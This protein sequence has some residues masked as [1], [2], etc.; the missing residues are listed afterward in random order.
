MR[1]QVKA[2]A[3][4]A[5]DLCWEESQ[6]DW[7]PLSKVLKLET[8]PETEIP[9]PPPP[10]TDYSPPTATRPKTAKLYLL[11]GVG[12]AVL[13]ALAFVFLGGD[14]SPDEPIA[15]GLIA[16]AGDWEALYTGKAHDS[17]IRAVVFDPHDNTIVAS[18]S[19]LDGDP[20]KAWSYVTGETHAKISGH[21][22]GVMCLAYH[23]TEELL[24]SGSGDDQVIIHDL[25][26]RQDDII[27]SHEP[28]KDRDG[29]VNALAWSAK[30]DWLVTGSMDLTV[31]LWNP[32]TGNEMR[33]ITEHQLEINGVAFNP[34]D[35]KIGASVCESGE[36]KIWNINDASARHL[37]THVD[38]A[39]AL[40]FSP[41]GETLAT[42]GNDSD[43]KIW[44]LSDGET[45]MK[46]QGHDEGV[47]SVAFHPNGRWLASGSDDDTVIIWDLQTK[48]IHRRLKHDDDVNTV[49]FSK[50]GTRLASADANG[51]VKIWVVPS[52]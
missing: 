39:A 37:C 8:Q 32:K 43:I 49:S 4:A 45:L 31:R 28:V 25:T 46:L 42:A 47:V 17:L 19:D 21:S 27:L 26:G 29:T 35:N 1:A 5:T 36:V 15:P 6:A 14:T 9:T 7:V 23:P 10:D 20:P 40:T 51:V 13:A 2:G 3:F 52:E 16:D 33:R 24:A 11:A 12:A 41:D 34:Q 30:G 22:Y 38:G 50:D 44:A 18:I 48:E